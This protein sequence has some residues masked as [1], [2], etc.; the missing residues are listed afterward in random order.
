MRLLLKTAL[1]ARMRLESVDNVI[2]KNTHE[3]VPSPFSEKK[4]T[5]G[6]RIELSALSPRQDTAGEMEKMASIWD[7]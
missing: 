7:F 3:V 4:Q 1:T 2:H 5:I 6:P